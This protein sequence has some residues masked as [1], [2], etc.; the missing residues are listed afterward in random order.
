MLIRV[1][2]QFPER[3]LDQWWGSRNRTGEGAGG[4]TSGG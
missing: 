1:V 2:R 4:P 3:S